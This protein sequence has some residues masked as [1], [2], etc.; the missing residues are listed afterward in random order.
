MWTGK[1]FQQPQTFFTFWLRLCKWKWL[2]FFVKVNMSTINLPY[3]TMCDFPVL[4][5]AED[6]LNLVYNSEEMGGLSLVLCSLQCAPWPWQKAVTH[7]STLCRKSLLVFF[8][9]SPSCNSRLKKIM[10]LCSCLDQSSKED[11]SPSAKA[12]S[13]YYWTPKDP[14]RAFPYIGT[15]DNTPSVKSTTSLQLLRPGCNL[16]PLSKVTK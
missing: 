7:Q 3:W 2:H 13:F 14:A 9:L 6:G 8:Y 12:F 16:G 15:S 1:S 11:E 4:P 5:S 10:Q